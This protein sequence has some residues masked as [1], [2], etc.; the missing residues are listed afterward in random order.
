MSTI[1]HETLT[2][3]RTIAAPVADLWDAYADAA[4]RAQ[5]SV[6]EG[7][8]MVYDAADFREGGRDLY[9]CGPPEALEFHAV[10]D[11][12]RIVPHR[13][14]VYAERVRTDEQALAAGLLTWEFEEH[15]DGTRVVITC[16]M[17]S[18]VGEGMIEGNRNGHTAALD[19][20]EKL[21]APR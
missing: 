1:A 2:I 21:L 14:I 17:A 16:Q 5:W 4:I 12:V 8:A 6:P 9:R 3:S 10:V 11:Y 13:L 20:L 15:G 19:Q 18:F 7:E